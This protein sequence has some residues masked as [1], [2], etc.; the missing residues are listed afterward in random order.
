MCFD[1]KVVDNLK[2]LSYQLISSKVNILLLRT[3][4]CIYLRVIIVEH[5]I[6]CI[7]MIRLEKQKNKTHKN[8]ILNTNI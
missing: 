3:D 4:L 6:L 8:T 2:R 7:K 5:V 1:I